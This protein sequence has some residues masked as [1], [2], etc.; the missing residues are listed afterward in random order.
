MANQKFASQEFLSVL[1]IHRV[2]PHYTYNTNKYKASILKDYVEN[3]DNNAK[4][5]TAYPYYIG[6]VYIVDNKIMV[7]FDVM[8][9]YT[10]IPKVDTPN[11]IKGFVN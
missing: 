5:S 6:N 10:N 9:L 2:A 8:S 4:N 7:S 3:K 11:I 1:L